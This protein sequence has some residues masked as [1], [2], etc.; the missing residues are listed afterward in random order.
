[1]R[2]ITGDRDRAWLEDLFDRHSRHLRAFAVRRVGADAADDVVSEVF[3]TA[4]R[5]RDDVPDPALAWLFQTARHAV[6]HQVRSTTRRTALH[7]TVRDQARSDAAPSA[8]NQAR[9]LVEAVLDE[10]PAIEAEI[11]RLTVWEELTPSEMAVVLDITP[12]AAR[13]RLMR[14]R[15]RAQEVYLAQLGDAVPDPAPTPPSSARRSTEEEPMTMLFEEILRDADPAADVAPYGAD[16]R[17]RLLD[18][19]I[20]EADDAAAA[21][22]GDATTRTAT[23]PRRGSRHRRVRVLLAACAA[24][25]VASLGYQSVTASVGAAEAAEVLGQAA[26]HASDPPAKPGQYWEITRI[27][28]NLADGGDGESDRR[29]L[30]RTTHIAYV[31]VDGRRP[32]WLVAKPAVTVRQVFGPPQ[33]RGGHGRGEAWTSNLSPE[34]KPG[35]WGEPSP[36]WFASLPREAGKLRARLYA[37]TE[38]HGNNP[39]DEAFI[40]IADVLRSGVVP[41][42]LRA[43]LYN[44]LKTIPGTTV[45]DRQVRLEDGRSGVAIGRNDIFGSHDELVIDPKTGDV[46]GERSF[47]RLVPFVGEELAL[48][49]GAQRRLVDAIPADI[50]RTAERQTCKV[51]NG[52]VECD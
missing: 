8:E 33:E 22:G 39:D 37:D 16:A 5:R 43:A 24:L 48:S 36:S 7:A 45:T 29:Y 4:W 9:V 1:M 46:I 6:M 15:Q 12:G 49:T 40:Y 27:G 20:S 30:V 42:D 32:T 41:A 14:A 3:A 19:A 11:L 35:W 17:R 23:S 31:S 47:M 38:G 28:T 25:V 10:L 26:I 52:E 13:T 2:R 50:Q 21:D 34:Q 51:V 44:V 18:A